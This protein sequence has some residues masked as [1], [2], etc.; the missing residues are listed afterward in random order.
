M[1]DVARVI[2][3]IFHYIERHLTLGRA[4][5][6][7]KHPHARLTPTE[8]QNYAELVTEDCMVHA[9]LFTDPA[10]FEEGLERV[11]A[12]SWVHPLH[13]S[14]I[15]VCFEFQTLRLG[16]RSLIVTRDVDGLIHVLLDRCTHCGTILC[17]LER[18]NAKRFQRANHG[19]T[20]ANTGQLTA[21]IYPA[22]DRNDCAKDDTDVGRAA[23]LKRYRS[24]I[25]C[26]SNPDVA[27]VEAWL[28]AAKTELDSEIDRAISDTNLR[29]V[30]AP[31]M[32]YRGN[33][34][35]QNDNNG[36]MYHVPFTHRPT[37][38]MTTQRHG[39]RRLLD[40]VRGDQRPMTD[41]ALGKG[42]KLIDRRPAID[43]VW[44]RGRPIPGRGSQ[45]ATLVSE[46]GETRARQYLE[47]VG[48]S[49]VDLV[50][51]PKL[52]IEGGDGRLI[53]RV[54]EPITHRFTRRHS[55]VASLRR[56][57]D[58][59]N[60][61]RMRFAQGFTDVRNRD[62]LEVFEQIQQSQR[63]ITSLESLDIR[64]GYRTS[65]DK[66]EGGI[67]AGNSTDRNSIRLAYVRWKELMCNPECSEHNAGSLQSL[68]NGQA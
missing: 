55:D 25:F 11:F 41:S 29:A 52:V 60:T 65:R 61:L 14:K 50:I 35:L 12:R 28:G 7:P 33:W 22:G 45:A 1:T 59:I 63:S 19:W 26:G 47:D 49:G 5:Q 34:K 9:G 6:T 58:Q 3:N 32:E 46:I 62:D 40:H 30:R 53:W 51:A 68:A 27:S 24:F 43:L 17:P 4:M 10:I 66:R 23:R 39:P 56:V 8:A 64:K 2:Y 18:G 36:A 67:T 20:F 48:R 44:E 16:R 15:P 38:V 54:Y 57:P 13:E 21:I 31:S 42:H 37:V